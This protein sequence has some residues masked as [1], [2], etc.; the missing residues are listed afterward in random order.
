MN[1]VLREWKKR[2]A[3]P[4]VLLANNKMVS[5]TLRDRFPFPYTLKEAER[6]ISFNLKKDPATNFAIEADGLLTGGC[7]IML[8]ED[9]Y[10][11]SGEI[12]YWLGH[13]FWGK[14]IA[15]EALRILLEMIPGR[16]PLLVRIY[17]EVFASNTA[18]IRVLEKNGFHLESIRKKSIVKN[19]VI[20]NDEVWV[21]MVQ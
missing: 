17:A 1:I 2:D 5:D 20:L 15:T 9:I 10:R 13:P 7:G 3:T 8:K 12:G 14:G 4:L 18:S 19:N 11:Y 6:W 16:F 21:K